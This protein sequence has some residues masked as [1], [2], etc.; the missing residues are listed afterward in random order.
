LPLQ[1]VLICWVLWAAEPSGSTVA[2]A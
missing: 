1:Y 2:P